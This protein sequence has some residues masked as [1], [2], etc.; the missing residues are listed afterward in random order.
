MRSVGRWVLH[1]P[2]DGYPQSSVIHIRI[3]YIPPLA[4]DNDNDVSWSEKQRRRKVRYRRDLA[5]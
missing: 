1:L 2:K 4:A 5:Q 3:N